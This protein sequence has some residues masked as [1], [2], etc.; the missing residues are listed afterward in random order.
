[1]VHRRPT[2][3]NHVVLGLGLWFV[4]GLVL[5]TKNLVPPCDQASSTPPGDT[6]LAERARIGL[7]IVARLWREPK[8]VYFSS[9]REWVK[10]RPRL[11]LKTVAV[12]T[13]SPEGNGIL[14]YGA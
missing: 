1:V 13:S 3:N 9:T 10:Q 5:G 7:K 6:V 14:S 12:H 11:R 2:A 4:L 8:E